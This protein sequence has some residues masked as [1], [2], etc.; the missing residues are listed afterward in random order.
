MRDNNSRNGNGRTFGFALALHGGAGTIAPG[1]A[2]H[3]RPYRAGLL[4]A[5]EAGRAVLAAG[6][7]ALDAVCA[8]VVSLED[9]ALFN[10]GHGAVLNAAGD[11]E[12][13]AAVMDGSSLAAGALA[14]VR[15]VRN[16]VLGAR[17][18]MRQGRCVLIIG[19]AGDALAEAAGLACV[20]NRYFRTEHRVGQWRRAHEAGQIMTLDHDRPAATP[21]YGTVGAVA[22]D[23]HGHLAAA[24]STG[25]MTGKPVGRVG[26]SPI[27]GAGVYA[28]DASCAVS[29]TGT[30]EHFI[31]ACLAHDI[32][33]RLTYGAG[34]LEQ[35]AGDAI[36]QTLAG[37]G[38]RGG[39]VVINRRGE[40]AMP[41]NSTGMYRAWLRDGEVAHTAI[42]GAD[43]QIAAQSPG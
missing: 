40:I 6:G 42:F 37:I 36:G 1:D 22:L 20:D 13:D 12:L 35:A 21:G 43:S 8:T 39:V 28:N 11:H 9:C 23:R 7:S 2:D 19:G 34:S 33:A 26:D 38:G 18:V 31:R 5:L 16:P 25:G 32:H 27:I 14:G 3:E 41:F 4:A 30:G 29:A 24:T 17:E 10:A 15:R